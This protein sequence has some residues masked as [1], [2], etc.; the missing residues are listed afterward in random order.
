[1]T[2]KEKKQY[3]VLAV[4]VV[5]LLF[6]LINPGKGR[7]HRKNISMNLSVPGIDVSNIENDVSMFDQNLKLIAS[8]EIGD[9]VS[10]LVSD[11]DKTWDRNPFEFLVSTEIEKVEEVEDDTIP[12]FTINGIIYDD[13][14]EDSSVVIEGEF[15]P[16]GAT[17]D[18]WTIVKIERDNVLFQNAAR[19]LEY[20]FYLYEDE[21]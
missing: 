7:H 3:I 5:I 2:D 16:E 1:M 18:G 9:V 10:K 6:L 19:N 17:V 4:G 13:I 8:K 15:Y 20:I 14:P 11:D 12:N 21:E